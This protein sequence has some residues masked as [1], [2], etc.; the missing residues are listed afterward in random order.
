MNSKKWFHVYLNVLF[1]Q[2]L[3]TLEKLCDIT[4]QAA[5]TPNEQWFQE[6][7]SQMIFDAI[8]RLQNPPNP[9]NPQNS[10]Q[11]L[12]Q[13]KRDFCLHSLFICSVNWY[14]LF[15]GFYGK[16]N[17]YTPI[18]Q[19]E[20]AGI[21]ASFTFDLNY[22]KH[23]PKY[24][25]IFSI[26]FVHT[27]VLKHYTNTCKHVHV[28]YQTFYKGTTSHSHEFTHIL[29]VNIFIPIS[30]DKSCG[31]LCIVFPASSQ[32]ARALPEAFKPCSKDGWDQFQASRNEQHCYSYPWDQYYGRGK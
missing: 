11:G 32:F 6:T 7:Y 31:K 8:D 2:V 24:I 13:V 15:M 21:Y 17:Y 25:C 10:C 1:L 29:I 26:L 9:S 18:C 14:G 28:E 5:E 30:F 23:I 20:G 27:L 16:N 4:I 12:K 19:D 22:E 3:F